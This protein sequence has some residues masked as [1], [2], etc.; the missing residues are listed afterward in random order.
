[1]TTTHPLQTTPVLCSCLDTAGT[2]PSR[3]WSPR[4]FDAIPWRMA[5]AGWWRTTRSALRERR[6]LSSWTLACGGARSNW[7]L[8]CLCTGQLR[9]PRV[10]SRVYLLHP[11]VCP[12]PAWYI[13]LRSLHRLEALCG[14]VA[15]GPVALN[16]Q[17]VVARS[18]APLFHCR[19]SRSRSHRPLLPLVASHFHAANTIFLLLGMP[20]IYFVM[21]FVRRHDL[22]PTFAQ[23]NSDEI[24]RLE[25][26]HLSAECRYPRVCHA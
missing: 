17:R 1:V 21:L 10:S 7:S 23:P 26:V 22:N 11:C 13:L 15:R 5:I 19:L 18:I 25:E 14:P 8:C 6:D 20:A 4:P 2:P 16:S 24:A 12:F 9:L 3:R